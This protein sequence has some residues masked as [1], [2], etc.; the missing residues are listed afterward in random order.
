M[1]FP[2]ILHVDENGGVIGAAH[3]P[4]N[5]GDAER[6][7]MGPPF[8]GTAVDGAEGVPHLEA[9]EAGGFAANHRFPFLLK[10]GALLKGKPG[11][12]V[13]YRAVA[14]ESPVCAY[15]AESPVIV[16]EAQRIH[17]PGLSPVFQD[18]HF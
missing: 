10:Q 4:E 8:G 16:T 2:H 1:G 15:Q 3:R 11:I 9:C 7:V 13:F 17:R 12:F 5:A 18:F 14:K 6:V